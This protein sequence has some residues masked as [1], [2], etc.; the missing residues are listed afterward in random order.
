MT[1][2]Q[3]KEILLAANLSLLERN[4]L[5]FLLLELE[6]HYENLPNEEWRD[7]IGYEGGYQ[8]SNLGR[9]KSLQ[10]KKT[11]IVKPDIIHTGYL[12]VMFYKDGKTKSHYT[13]VLVAKAF[14]PNPDNKS[15][16][17]H[18]N[19]VK[20]DNRV[21]NLEWTTRSENIIHAFA[22]GLSKSGS[23]HGRA[24]LTPNQVREI[25]RDCIPGDPERGFKA[26]A[27]KFKVTPKI[28]ENAYNHISYKDVD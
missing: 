15:D 2:D 1:V 4:A 23:K 22:N 10:R 20:T 12:R 25:R 14:I 5:Q 19:G 17:N 27:R 7:A 11:R 21:E 18:I 24:K 26:F 9:I 13:H 16:V 6:T 8:V 3:A 28:I